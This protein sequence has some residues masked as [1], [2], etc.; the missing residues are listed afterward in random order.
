VIEVVFLAGA[1]ADVQALYEERE[2]FREKAGDRFLRELDPCASLA[3]GQQLGSATAALLEK[4]LS[5]ASQLKIRP[6]Y[7]FNIVVTKDLEFQ[8]PY[9]VGNY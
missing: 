9:Y 6:G 4:N 7:R 3:V 8:S 2:R 1:E 5:I